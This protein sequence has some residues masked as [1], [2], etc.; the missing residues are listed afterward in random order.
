MNKIEYYSF[1][2]FDTL[3]TRLLDKPTD[4]FSIMEKEYNI[5]NFKKNRINAE[6][7][8]RKSSKHEEITIDEIYNELKIIDSSINTFEVKKIEKELEIKLCIINKNFIDTYSNLEEENKKIIIISDMY[9]DSDTIKKILSKN[10]ISFDKLYLSSEIK[11]T[12]HTGSLYDY[13]LNDLNIKSNQIIHYGD[14]KNSDFINPK[15]RGIKSVLVNNNWNNNLS[16]YNSKV[17]DYRYLTMEKFINSNIKNK[18]S[19][20]RLNY[21]YKAGYEILGPLLYGFCK[22]LNE[23]LNKN[24]IKKVFFLARDGKIMK[25]S[26]DILYPEVNTCYMFASR[27]AL[28]VPTL[29]LYKELKDPSYLKNIYFISGRLKM[30]DLIKMLGLDDNNIDH[31]LKKYNYNLT[32]NINS[33]VISN[34]SEFKSFYNEIYPLILENSKNEYDEMVKYL[35]E[36]NFCENVGIVDIGWNGNMQYALEKATKVS[37]INAKIKGFYIGITCNSK[38]QE[39]QDM[40][41]YLYQKDYNEKIEVYKKWYNAIFEFFFSSTDGSFK[42]YTDD[43]FEFYE[44]EYKNTKEREYLEKIQEG[45]IDFV[46]DFSKSEL[47]DIININPSIAILNFNKLGNCPS[48]EDL[49]YFK[50]ITFY[51][52]EKHNPLIKNSRDNYIFHPK[53]FVKDYMDSYW[54]SGF[55]N[56]ALFSNFDYTLWINTYEKLIEFIKK[57][58]HIRNS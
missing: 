36:I 46:H 55:L 4:L 50:E 6:R 32:D 42:C 5:A 1:D 45:A 8:A 2:M 56:F 22:W 28:T 39:V 24:H 44:Y 3:I 9:L 11:K 27:R 23:N 7:K 57:V 15:K 52:N 38:K 48:D 14:N 58:I 31:I 12:K 53:Y 13:V 33:K 26:F 43:G 47:S 20:L 29:C 21:F 37:N 41:G 25:K 16:F 35:K 54:R 49:N 34:D 19:D 30:V 10:G 18:F 17:K 40:S 51:E